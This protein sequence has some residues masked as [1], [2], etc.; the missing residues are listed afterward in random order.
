MGKINRS[1]QKKEHSH[2]RLLFCK[3]NECLKQRIWCMLS[4]PVSILR[5]RA[6][7]PKLAGSLLSKRSPLKLEGASFESLRVS[8]KKLPPPF[9]FDKRQ[10]GHYERSL[11]LE[12]SLECLES[13]KVLQ[14]PRIHRSARH[15]LLVLAQLTLVAQPR[16][17]WGTPCSLCSNGRA[18]SAEL[19]HQRW[20][21]QHPARQSPNLILWHYVLGMV[22]TY[23]HRGTC[24]PVQ[25]DLWTLTNVVAW[26]LY[27]NEAFLL[28]P[29]SY[30][31]RIIG[32]RVRRDSLRKGPAI[33][34]ASLAANRFRFAA[35]GSAPFKPC[36]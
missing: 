30:S 31:S 25:S 3:Q 21:C 33:D 24:R 14:Q 29:L 34:P 13:L 5:K 36:H 20:S 12:G 7:V 17:T 23:I 11:S 8:T 15:M 19:P 10:S 1:N 26:Y 4:L 22:R 16:S 18:S 27:L 9:F 6:G 35:S 32:L 28:P 2:L